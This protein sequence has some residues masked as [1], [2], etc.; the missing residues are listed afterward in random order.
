V[1]SNKKNATRLGAHLVFVDESGFL[2]I[3]NV[4]KTWAPRGQTPM[5]R[6]RYRHDKVSA[7]SGVSVSPT[8]RRFGLYCLLFEKNIQQEEVCV[9]LRSLLKHLRGHVIVLLD[10]GAIH[11]GQPLSD[12]CDCFPRLHLEFFPA[13]APELNPDE[14][15]WNHLKRALSNGRPDNQ[16]ELMETLVQE[17]RKL[18]GSQT[19]LRGCIE[20]SDLPFVLR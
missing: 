5:C 2:L 9:F 4:R 7:I 16:N 17:L 13:Y 3:P 14:G 6:Y 12:L 20:H 19:L 15:V 11:K 10:N 18:S 1:A 8:R